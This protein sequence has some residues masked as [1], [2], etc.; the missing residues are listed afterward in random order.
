MWQ[1]LRE[2][3][4]ILNEPPVCQSCEVL[5]T[6][7]SNLRR[8]KDI[9]LNRLMFPTEV[10]VPKTAPEPVTMPS[11]RFKPWRVIQQELEQKDAREA[12]RIRKEFEDRTASLENQIGVADGKE[13]V[14]RSGT[15]PGSS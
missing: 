6:E 3:R 9:L 1:W 10:D 14:Q 2:L 4:E 11:S 8:D 13:T 12:A 15:V 5:K 7:I